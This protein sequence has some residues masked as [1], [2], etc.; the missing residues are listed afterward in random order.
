MIIIVAKNDNNYW[1]LYTCTMKLYLSIIDRLYPPEGIV[2]YCDNHVPDTWKETFEQARLDLVHIEQRI[3][4]PYFPLTKDVFK[5]FD[6]C[7]LPMIRVVIIGQDPYHSEENGLPQA[8]GLAFSTRKGHTIQPSLKNIYYELM[9][10]YPNMTFPTHGDLSSW[11]TQGVFL[12]NTC[13]TVTPHQ[14]GS[15][16]NI[17]IGFINRVLMAI[18]ASNPQCIFLLWGSKAI[19]LESL[20]GGKAIKLKASHPSPLSVHKAFKDIPAFNG[21]KH[22]QQVNK[23][24]RDREEP[25]INWASVCDP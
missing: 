14:A 6:L 17:W 5:A 25:E 23:I 12:L 9:R 24:L 3:P 10:E 4:K 13:L 18:T 11:C 1:L 21:C 7:P 19:E 15:H 16:K 2:D 22:F 8:T 20:I